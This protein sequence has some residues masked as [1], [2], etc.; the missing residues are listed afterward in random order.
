MLSQGSGQ[1][2][3]SAAQKASEDA[4]KRLQDAKRR[5]EG[6]KGGKGGGEELKRMESDLKKEYTASLQL[7]TT[8]ISALCRPLAICYSTLLN[9]FPTSIRCISI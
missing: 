1:K 7:V 2:E 8:P 4:E 9:L 3:V 6:A 5:I